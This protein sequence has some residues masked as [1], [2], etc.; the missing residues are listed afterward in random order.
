VTVF[1]DTS[2]FYALLDD[3]DAQHPRAVRGRDS[4]RGTPVITHSYVVIETLALVRRRLGPAAA[5]R[6]IDELIP[7]LA[8]V[9]VDRELREE[10]TR[11]YRAAGAAKVSLVDQ[12]SFA[13]MRRHGLTLAW[14]LDADFTAAGFELVA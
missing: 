1:G 7:L 14:A 10:A 3:E 2:A 11:S 8:V 9:D 6:V 13:F 12:T 4:L 5:L